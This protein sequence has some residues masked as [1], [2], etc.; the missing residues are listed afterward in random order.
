MPLSPVRPAGW[1][2]AVVDARAEIPAEHED[3]EALVVWGSSRSH[4]RSAAANLS[5]L[6]LV[7]SLSAGVDGIIAAGFRD[8]VA[9]ASGVGLHDRTVTEHT[10]ALLLTMVRR[11]PEAEAA[12][13]RHEWS[14]SLGGPQALHPADRV[15]TLLGANVVIWGFGSI[16]K[17]LAPILRALGANVTGVAHTEGD[18]AGFPVVTAA[19]LPA[20]LPTTDVLIGI[21]PGTVETERAIGADVFEALPSRALVINVGRGVTLDQVALMDALTSGSI[22][23]AALDVTTPEPLPAEDPLWDAPRLIIT[24]H[25]AGG[26]PVGADDRISHNI[27]A[28]ENGTRLTHR[29][30]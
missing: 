12:R 16:A 5:R 6:R 25:G 9:I 1:S 21:L 2:T 26:R 13:R 14:R 15:T 29:A 28:L 4:L 7:Q 30:R 23:G 19:D 3:A 27:A 11:L 24:P 8:D 22:A 20:L 18:R 17:T 10:L